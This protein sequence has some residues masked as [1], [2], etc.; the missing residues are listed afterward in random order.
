[1]L[2][3][4]SPLP[5]CKGSQ[6]ES[7]HDQQE[8]R[9]GLRLH[10]IVLG[11]ELGP[12]LQAKITAC[13]QGSLPQAIPTT[14]RELSIAIGDLGLL[15]RQ[16]PPAIPTGAYLSM[17]TDMPPSFFYSGRCPCA[18]KGERG[19]HRRYCLLV[20]NSCCAPAMQ[21]M[22]EVDTAS[23][24][25]YLAEGANHDIQAMQAHLCAHRASRLLE[26]LCSGFCFDCRPTRLP[27][28][29]QRQRRAREPTEAHE[30]YWRGTCRASI[31]GLL[32]L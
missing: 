13:W 14:I 12:E 27:W 15:T 17:R 28:K 7:Y 18:T 6:A 1:M 8:G 16:F 31:S 21:K 23:V 20:R 5:G 10:G 30:E 22:N 29:T 3:L 9:T 19:R 11:K 4:S 25:A 26:P 32:S 24:R 2:N